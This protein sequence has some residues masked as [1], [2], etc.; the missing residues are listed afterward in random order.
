[1]TNHPM[2]LVLIVLAALVLTAVKWAFLPFLP[3]RRLPR[4]RVRHLR[5]RA[6]PAAAPR[7]RARHRRRAVAAVG[8]VRGV[9]PQPAGPA[10]P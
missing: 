8:P 9:P 7:R 1:M 10:G 4:N 2:I 6:A 5:L 3:W